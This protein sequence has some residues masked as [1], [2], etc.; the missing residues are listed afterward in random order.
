MTSS[1]GALLSGIA[2]LGARRV[3]IVTPYMKPLTAAVVAYLEDAGIEVVDAL[4]LGLRFSAV[5]V[6]GAAIVAW[7]FLPSH[8]SHPTL[9]FVDVSEPPVT[10]TPSGQPVPAPSPVAGN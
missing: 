10:M 6:I 2:A 4:S 1:A 5:A 3:A 7:K 9:E 8:A